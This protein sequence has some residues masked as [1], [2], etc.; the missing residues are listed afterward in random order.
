MC[1][2]KESMPSYR[3]DKFKARGWKINTNE[4]HQPL[5]YKDYLTKSCPINPA[6]IQSICPEFYQKMVV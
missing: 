3:L 2:L 5:I 4:V 6:S 1:T